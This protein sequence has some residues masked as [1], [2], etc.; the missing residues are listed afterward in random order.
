HMHLYS[1][2]TS[3]TEIYPLSLHDALPIC[4]RAFWAYGS[5]GNSKA[6]E[7]LLFRGKAWLARRQRWSRELGLPVFEPANHSI[8]P[9]PYPRRRSG[10]TAGPASG[11][12][13]QAQRDDQQGG[14]HRQV[15]QPPG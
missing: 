8:R 14:R 3:T 6:I 9:L 7:I 4:S 13:G 12:Q 10:A 2:D 5:G 1:N 11:V 15:D